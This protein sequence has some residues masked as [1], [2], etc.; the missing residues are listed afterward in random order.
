KIAVLATGANGS[1]TGADLTRAGHDVILID[2]S[3]AH[4]EAMRKAGL[5]TEMPEEGLRV[6]AI[7][8]HHRCDGCTLSQQFDIVLL[9]SKAYDGR[10]LAEFIKPYLAE[11]GLL[12]GVQNSMTLDSL[13]EIVGPHRT[14][15]CVI[16][17]S[18][19]VYVPGIVQ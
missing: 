9:M 10:W 7:R 1:C 13:T 16:E 11:D 14:F 15:G 18:S 2:Q 6:Q 8:A 17:L 4:A 5:L 3:P 12:V 19:E